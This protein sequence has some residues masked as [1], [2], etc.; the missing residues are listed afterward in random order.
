VRRHGGGVKIV[1]KSCKIGAVRSQVKKPEK[2]AGGGS[3]Y[4][5]LFKKRTYFARR[6]A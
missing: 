6:K 2:K 5:V 4:W 3:I 1:K